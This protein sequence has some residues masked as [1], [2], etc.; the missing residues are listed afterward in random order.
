MHVSEL[1]DEDLAALDA[2]EIPT[3]AARYNHEM[4]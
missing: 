3:E 1:T 4:T 2:V